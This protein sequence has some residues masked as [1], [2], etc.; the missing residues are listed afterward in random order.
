V[1]A[2]NVARPS[3][4]ARNWGNVDGGNSFAGADRAGGGREVAGAF[5]DADI[6]R[7]G[8]LFHEDPRGV[9]SVR[10]DDDHPE[11]TDDGDD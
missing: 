11:L 6:G 8:H 5:D 10:I 1:E 3:G 7:R 9:R 2:A 4:R